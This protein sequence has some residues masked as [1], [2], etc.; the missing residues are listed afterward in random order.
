MEEVKYI[1]NRWYDDRSSKNK[2]EFE[3]LSTDI[4]TGKVGD[5][6]EIKRGGEPLELFK[7]ILEETGDRIIP[8]WLNCDKDNYKGSIISEPKREQI[9]S[10]VNMTLIVELYSK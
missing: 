9:D 6:I 1:V 4:Y 2:F 5:I 8:E 3:L 10:D 7:M